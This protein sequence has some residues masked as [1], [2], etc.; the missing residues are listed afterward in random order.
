MRLTPEF[1]ADVGARR[2]L[3]RAK[4]ENAPVRNASLKPSLDLL[5][6][7]LAKNDI[8]TDF[9]LDSIQGLRE[10]AKLDMGSSKPAVVRGARERLQLANDTEAMLEQNLIEKG[11]FTSLTKFR[12]ARQ[13][14]AKTYDAEK[15]TLD[16]GEI[17]A[18]A[19]ADSKSPLSGGLAEIA[20]LQ[21]QFHE[22][23]QIPTRI[24]RG[25]PAPINPFG[26]TASVVTHALGGNGLWSSAGQ[27]IQSPL[28]SLLKSDFY[29]KH[30]ATPPTYAPSL[31]SRF[32][33]ELQRPGVVL[34]EESLGI[35]E[36]RRQEL[37]RQL[38]EQGALQ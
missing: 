20:D 8:N 26:S 31:G 36:R 38:L 13:Q 10:V 34:G 6:E 4:F 23:T 27:A 30:M 29:Q 33:K 24:D 1:R 7:A 28:R 35:N 25:A 11:D 5:D 18:K 3:L 22:A 9:A 21:R 12:Q 19:L 15:A 37:L 16:T 32:V 14:I 2:D 17:Y